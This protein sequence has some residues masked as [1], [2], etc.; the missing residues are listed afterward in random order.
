MIRVAIAEDDFRIAS[1]QEQ[2]LD[3]LDGFTFVGKALNAA[4][5]VALLDKTE[6]DLLL[7]DIYMPD[8]LGTELLPVLKERFPKTDII[9]I[10]AAS[11]KH[12]LQ[13][14]LRYGVFHYL[15]KPVSMEKFKSVMEEYEKKKHLLAAT[16]HV[17][18]DVVDA[19]FA[20]TVQEPA[21]QAAQLPT[22]ID[23]VTLNRISGV[24]QEVESGIS[25]EEMG[26]EIGASRTTARRYLEYL[27]TIGKCRVEHE[28]GIVGRPE[29]RYFNVK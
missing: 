15:V 24:L 8:M 16:D 6:T 25:I 29:R 9:M 3:Q 27:V 5:T 2:F 20:G 1:I 17:T 14:A 11:E 13:E 26:A 21:I 10:T 4:D 23:G 28:Y 22:G 18:Q 12:M 19:Y 7:L